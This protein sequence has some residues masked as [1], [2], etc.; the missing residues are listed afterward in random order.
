MKHLTVI[1]RGA[2]HVVFGRDFA[3]PPRALYDA[4]TRADLINRWMQG[5]EGCTLTVRTLDLRPGGAFHYDCTAPGPYTFSISGN[6]VVLDA[7]HRIEHVERMTLPG[8]TPE[9]TPDNRC[10]TT[11]AAH[12]GGTRMTMRM[13]VDDPATLEAMLASGMEVGM[14]ASYA[15]FEALQPV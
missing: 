6:F 15:R 13:E 8:M 10:T 9:V 7:P 2:T 1:E 12:A 14:E 5:P 4:H 11:F 3:A